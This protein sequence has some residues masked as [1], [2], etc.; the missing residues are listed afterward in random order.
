[1]KE[2]TAANIPLV[3]T[4]AVGVQPV[5]REHILVHL[6]NGTFRVLDVPPRHGEDDVLDCVAAEVLF[7]EVL[8]VARRRR[9]SLPL[10]YKTL[11]FDLAFHHSPCSSS[12]PSTK[13]R[14]PAR[15]DVLDI[16]IRS[17]VMRFQI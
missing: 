13:T 9:F 4:H 1:M 16:L 2:Q 15:G 10:V 3:A 5:R 12:P 14:S 6:A 8:H 17:E 11:A 7:S